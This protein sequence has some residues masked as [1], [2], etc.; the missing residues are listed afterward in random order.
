MKDSFSTSITT[1]FQRDLL[2]LR[3]EVELQEN[4]EI[5]WSTDK[6]ISNSA[7]NLALHMVGNL[8]YFIGTLMG[9]TGYI[10]HRPNEFGLKNISKTVIFQQ[11]DDTIEMIQTV[12]SK[13]TAEELNAECQ[14]RVF[15][16][17]TS[18]Q[19][20]LMHLYG[21]LNYHLGQVNYHRRLLC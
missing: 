10:R 20:F 1:L 11:I 18:N 4:E 8:N 3:K 14:G 6:N 21:H 17:P 5:L 13:M 15:E 19:K 9:K 16:E 2:R 12:L 7:G